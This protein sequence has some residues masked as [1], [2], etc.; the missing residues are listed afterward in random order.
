LAGL[1]LVVLLGAGAGVYSI[2][3]PYQGFHEDVFLDFPKGTSTRAIAGQLSQAGV[4]RYSWQFLAARAL[5]PSARLQAGE[6]R[7]AVTDSPANVLNRIARGDVFYYE[8]VAPEGSNIFEIAMIV[9][10]TGVIASKEFLRAA[11]DAAPIRDLDPA[12]KTLEGYLFPSK[13]RIT[14]RTT[15]EQLCKMMT[16]QFRH[17]WKPLAM[18]ATEPVHDTVTLASLIEKET[19]VPG[20][21]PVVASVYRNRLHREMKLDCDP[22]TIYAAMLEERYRGTI[23]QSDLASRNAYNTYHHAGLPPG[24]I[25]NP[26]VASLKAALAPADTSYLYFVAKPGGAGSHSFSSDYASHERNVQE[27][28]RGLKPPQ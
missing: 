3:V 14:R 27:Y 2:Y 21:R 12:A 25:T 23:Y 15:A 20:E 17:E 7:F 1:A 5:R 8:V 26:G 11:A 18:T 16:D 10:Q 28:R 24:P 4:I 6:Y 13:Y 22:T 9:E 19:S